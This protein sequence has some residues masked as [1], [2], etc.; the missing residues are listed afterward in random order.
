MNANDEDAVIFTGHGC[1][2][3]IKKIIGALDLREQPVVFTGPSEHQDNILLWQEAG[4]EVSTNISFIISVAAT[5]ISINICFYSV[6]ASRSETSEP[7]RRYGRTKK[8]QSIC[9]PQ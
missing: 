6:T 7:L 9:Y 5:S 8:F 1:S 3:A 4:A 2:D